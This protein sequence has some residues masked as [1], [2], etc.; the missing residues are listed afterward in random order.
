MTQI[1]FKSRTSDRTRLERARQ[2]ARQVSPASV[3][4]ASQGRPILHLRNTDEGATI[5]ESGPDSS[6]PV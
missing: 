2:A 4:G 5:S 6:E 3:N 1:T